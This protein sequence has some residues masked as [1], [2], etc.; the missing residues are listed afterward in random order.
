MAL[1]DEWATHELRKLLPL[2]LLDVSAFIKMWGKM[3]WRCKKKVL[4]QMLR[5]NL[6][7]F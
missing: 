4:E 1:G 2:T 7:P 6:K 3:V 5:C